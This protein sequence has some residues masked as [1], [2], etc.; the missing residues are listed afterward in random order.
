ME[1]IAYLLTTMIISSAKNLLYTAMI[2][3]ES[4]GKEVTISQ[5]SIIHTAKEIT[6]RMNLDFSTT[7]EK[8]NTELL[9]SQSKK[10][11]SQSKNLLV[12]DSKYQLDNEDNHNLKCLLILEEEIY[13]FLLSEKSL[14]SSSERK[15]VLIIPNSSMK[16]N[17]IDTLTNFHSLVNPLVNLLMNPSINRAEN[18]ISKK[19]C[20]SLFEKLVFLLLERNSTIT[21]KQMK[22]RLI[23]VNPNLA[24]N[25]IFTRFFSIIYDMVKY[26]KEQL[27]L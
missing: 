4:I 6:L 7:E 21:L 19:T 25:Q 11:N 14:D 22:Q 8:T 16:Y 13:Y 24:D 18:E 9:I 5:E 12:D 23:D 3:A 2:E 15:T 26:K 10:L 17:D 20:F 1:S 27:I